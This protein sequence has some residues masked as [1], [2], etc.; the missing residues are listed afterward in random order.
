MAPIL[1]I[2]PIFYCPVN[3]LTS[4]ANLTIAASFKISSA[5]RCHAH[6]VE[7][8]FAPSS[9]ASAL[10][11]AENLSKAE[12]FAASGELLH[13]FCAGVIHATQSE[14]EGF[15]EGGFQS[16]RCPV[17]PFPAGAAWFL[18]LDSLSSPDLASVPIHGV[19]NFCGHFFRIPCTGRDKSQ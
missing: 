12:R 14:G 3:L 13:L 10:T 7:C 8:C 18:S 5:D 17:I 16:S 2:F 4:C 19:R 11:I 9:F 15:S 1:H 6:W